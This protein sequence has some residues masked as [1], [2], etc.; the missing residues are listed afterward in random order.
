MGSIVP[1]I[2]DWFGFIYVGSGG[3]VATICVEDGI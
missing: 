3:I 2:A 1:F